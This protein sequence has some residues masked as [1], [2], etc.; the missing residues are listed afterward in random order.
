MNKLAL[1]G[2]AVCMLWSCEEDQ[3]DNFEINHIDLTDENNN[4]TD[5]NDVAIIVGN[6]DIAKIREI[7]IP[8]HI[9][10]DRVIRWTNPLRICDSC[11]FDINEDGVYD[12]TFYASYQFSTDY[13]IKCNFFWSVKS[14]S[15][16]CKVL[17][18]T[19]SNKDIMGNYDPQ[20]ISACRVEPRGLALLSKISASD[21]WAHTAPKE[22]R[23][24]P[25][26][27]DYFFYPFEGFILFR[28]IYELFYEPDPWTLKGN[29]KLS[30][31]DP[32]EKYIGLKLET[33][34]ITTLYWLLLRLDSV[35][36][37]T[38]EELGSADFNVKSYW[39]DKFVN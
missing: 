34:E 2:L 30:E 8:L 17:L 25:Y 1:L 4:H 13:S 21:I 3:K 28:F 19:I 5:K 7:N 26:M 9:D 16:N 15:E 37:M 35:W 32:I 36:T 39:L 22:Y 31:C 24:V 18:D 23:D 29:D 38:L 14:L 27:S 11:N 10:L 20:D 12:F 6:N 33:E